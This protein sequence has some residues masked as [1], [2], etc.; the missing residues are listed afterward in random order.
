M[1]RI[2]DK[3]RCMTCS[4]ETDVEKEMTR[5][6]FP[7]FCIGHVALFATG[8]FLVIMEWMN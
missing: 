6:L 5:K 3:F 4:V 2:V 7:K 1:K 8:I